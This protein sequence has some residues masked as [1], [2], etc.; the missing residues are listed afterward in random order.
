MVHRQPQG[1]GRTEHVEILA[2]Q[3]FR[4]GV[5]GCR[6]KTIFNVLKI[7]FC[8]FKKRVFVRTSA[9]EILVRSAD[10]IPIAPIAIWYAKS[11]AQPGLS[12]RQE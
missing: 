11:A 2:E 5:R 8:F 9:A 1:L 10:A 3:H 4:R 12:C 7:Q 6:R